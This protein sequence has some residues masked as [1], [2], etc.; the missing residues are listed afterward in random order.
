MKIDLK[1][2]LGEIKPPRGDESGL[3]VAAESAIHH[4]DFRLFWDECSGF[5]VQGAGFRVLSLGFKVQGS[6]FRVEG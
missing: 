2:T 4:A 3:E 5:R 1:N 6:S